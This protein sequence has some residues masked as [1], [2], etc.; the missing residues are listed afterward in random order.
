SISASQ[1]LREGVPVEGASWE[2]AGVEVLFT[3]V[4]LHRSRGAGRRLLTRRPSLHHF[5]LGQKVARARERC[6]GGPR[7]SSARPTLEQVETPSSAQITGTTA[8][9]IAASVRSLVERGELT[10]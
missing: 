2:V 5:D 9:E 7:G 6:A 4:F 10:P 8:A 1:S 3:A